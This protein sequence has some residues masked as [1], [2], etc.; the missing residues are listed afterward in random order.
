[1]SAATK[2]GRTLD[3]ESRFK[4]KVLQKVIDRIADVLGRSCGSVA[5]R[6]HR[7]GLPVLV[8][9]YD[10][11]RVPSLRGRQQSWTQPRAH[12]TAAEP[13]TKAAHKTANLRA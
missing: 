6:S 7:R 13:S 11:E 3:L 10:D 2:A 9:F 8:P 5:W 1:M 12:C 4:A